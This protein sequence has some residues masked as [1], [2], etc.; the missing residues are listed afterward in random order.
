MKAMC[1]HVKDTMGSWVLG[2]QWEKTELV[3]LRLSPSPSQIKTQLS[4]V[5]IGSPPSAGSGARFVRREG[6]FLVY[7]ITFRERLSFRM[8][9]GVNPGRGLSGV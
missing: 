6:N 5:G 7:D 3:A 8:R 9:S 1:T 2:I 4:N